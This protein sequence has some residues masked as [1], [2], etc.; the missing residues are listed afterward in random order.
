MRAKMRDC[1]GVR[2]KGYQH[3]DRYIEGYRVWYQHQDSN[4]WLGPQEVLYHRDY[5]VCIHTNGD[6]KKVASCKMKTYELIQ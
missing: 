1:Q 5:K 2:V 4:G 3:Q 6:V